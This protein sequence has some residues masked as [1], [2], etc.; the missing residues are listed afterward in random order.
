[1]FTIATASEHSAPAWRARRL[2]K[3]A[4]AVAD[5]ALI[6]ATNFLTMVLVARGL[7]GPSEFGAFTLVYSALLF[8]NILQVALITQPHNILGTARHGANYAAYTTSC[9]LA[10]LLLV[11]A[12]GSI[13]LLVWAVASQA[14]WAAAAMLLAL[15]PSVV[16]WQL[17]EFVRRV[18]YTEGRHAA[19]FA[20]DLISYGGQTLAVGALWTL[21]ALQE[22]GALA[23]HRHW[24]TGATA[25]Y[26]LA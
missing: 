14:H 11:L 23:T 26:A 21:D 3:D 10:Q 22:R 2:I 7:G 4:W 6:S 17:Q 24:L 9:G 16:A 12:E 5:Q 19:A 8:A 20:N 13:A 15:V 25:L 1:M 18:L